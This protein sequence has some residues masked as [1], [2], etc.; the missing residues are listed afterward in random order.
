MSAETIPEMP[1]EKPHPAPRRVT[2]AEYFAL[3]RASEVRLEYLDGAVRAM[4]GETPEH[5]RIV[6]NISIRLDAAYGERQCDVFIENIRTRVSRTRYRYPDIAALCGPAEF[7]DQSP[8]SLL[9]PAVIFEL[10]SPSTEE[11]DH[12]DKF[13]EYEGIETVTDYL[14]V[15]QDEIKVLH[16]T[17]KS[18]RNW[19]L[20]IYRDATDVLTLSS[21]NAS[22]SVSDIYRRTK[23]IEPAA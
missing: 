6:K 11:A 13:D 23:V 18:P 19:D 21:L 12:N 4:A 14:L 2:V 1:F 17:R 3:D 16:Y 20:V 22:I 8:P 15:A 5:N 10:L 7:D 9:N